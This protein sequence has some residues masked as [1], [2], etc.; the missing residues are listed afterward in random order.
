MSLFKRQIDFSRLVPPPG[1]AESERQW[2]Q[3]LAEREAAQRRQERAERVEGAH[4]MRVTDAVHKALIDGIPLLETESHRQ[5]KKWAL[6]GERPVLVLNGGVGCGKSVAA[7]WV[8][9]NLGGIW[10]PAERACRIFASNFGD[11][12]A[13]QTKARDVAMLILDDVGTELEPL[14]M[15]HVLTELLDSRKSRRHRLLIT[16]NLPRKNFEARYKSERLWSRLA[17]TVTWA[18]S[19]GADL[20]RQQ[21]RFDYADKKG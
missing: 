4:D 15:M 21:R 2:E 13:E 17:E 7:A 1:S 5:A 10:L 16:T 12:F 6:A 18:G 8:L 3:E 14:R 20:R 11:G 19:Q 9:A